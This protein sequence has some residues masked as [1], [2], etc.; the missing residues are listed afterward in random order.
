[1]YLMYHAAMRAV[2][3]AD[4]YDLAKLEAELFEEHMLPEALS[5]E[6]QAGFGWL[7]E[8]ESDLISYI[9]VRDDTHILDVTRFGTRTAYQGQ[10]YGGTLLRHVLRTVRPVMVT[11]DSENTVGIRM[12]L[13]HGF[14]FAGR[15]P[16]SD[17]WIMRS[18]RFR[19]F[20]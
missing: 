20:G 13:K 12:Y 2:T 15:L 4:A 16:H 11:V 18:D 1:M 5:A 8:N 3:S 19:T 10:A 7:I 6:I 9:L 17:N 14:R